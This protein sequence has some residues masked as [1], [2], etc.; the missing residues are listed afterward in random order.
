[1]KRN[2][3]N[4]IASNGHVTEHEP[5]ADKQDLLDFLQKTVLAQ[6]KKL[7]S[8]AESVHNFKSIDQL[9]TSQAQTIS[10]LG[11]QFPWKFLRQNLWIY[12]KWFQPTETKLIFQI[13]QFITF[14][15]KLFNL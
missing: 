9:G 5:A 13:L 2:M 10:Q 8:L 1:M 11:K 3:L 15:T 7:S 4:G 12:L 14:Y 6:D